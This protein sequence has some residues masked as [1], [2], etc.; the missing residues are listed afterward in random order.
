MS[1]AYRPPQDTRA[2]P[3]PLFNGLG[4]SSFVLGLLGLLFFWLVPLGILFSG[5]G[6]PLG[7]AGCVAARR[8]IRGGLAW[9]VGGTVLCLIAL[10]IGIDMATGGLTRQL[11]SN[12]Y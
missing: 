11:L 7:I 5:A 9:A 12:R 1:T 6:I 2:A 8:G 10:A 4:L 3:V